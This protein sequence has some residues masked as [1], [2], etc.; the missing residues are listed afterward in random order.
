MR[1]SVDRPDIACLRQAAA[2]LI[3][4]RRLLADSKQQTIPSQGPL[5]ASICAIE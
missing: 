1:H 2:L 5:H 4:K 3:E